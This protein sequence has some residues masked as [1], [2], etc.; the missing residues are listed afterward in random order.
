MSVGDGDV[1]IRANWLPT[2]EIMTM[3]AIKRVIK[4]EPALKS[5]YSEQYARYRALYPAI[6]EARS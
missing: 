3:P 1:R 4:P 5:A 6:E 2:A